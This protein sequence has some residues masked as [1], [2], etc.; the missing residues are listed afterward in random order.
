M[1][2]K[3]NKT[4]SYFDI[5]KLLHPDLNPDIEDPHIKMEKA[6]QFRTDEKA[7]YKLACQWKLIDDG[8]KSFTPEYTIEEGKIIKIDGKNG[9]I[10][11]VKRYNHYIDIYVWLDGSFKKFKKEGIK[12]Q[13]EKFYVVGYAPEQ[14]YMDADLKYQMIIMNKK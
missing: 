10:V 8:E 12:D 4:M 13:D 3:Q 5:V 2:D 11:D 7:L 1:V 9:I 14:E 6:I